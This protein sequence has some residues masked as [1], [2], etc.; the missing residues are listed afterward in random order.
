MPTDIAAA[1][2]ELKRTA[3]TL[4]D[5]EQWLTEHPDVFAGEQRT[6]PTAGLTIELFVHSPSVLGMA[7]ELDDI[8]VQARVTCTQEASVH[9]VL[10]ELVGHTKRGAHPVPVVVSYPLHLPLK[11]WPLATAF[12]A[13]YFIDERGSYDTRPY[14]QRL[15]ARLDGHIR[16][17]F[18]G[19]TLPKLVNFVEAG[20]IVNDEDDE[21]LDHTSPI[22]LAVAN[23][24]FASRDTN[25]TPELPAELSMY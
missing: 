10:D 2:A 4:A 18:P 22:V 12:V 15:G 8:L 19:M 7:E 11:D 23:L 9:P 20:F 14:M 3:Q 6:L 16:H 13:S 25:L 24:L 21:D 17:H 5:F 1:F